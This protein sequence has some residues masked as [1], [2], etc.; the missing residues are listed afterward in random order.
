MIAKIEKQIFGLPTR[1]KQNHMK[2]NHVIINAWSAPDGQHA[3][4][5][6]I[7]WW[8]HCCTNMSVYVHNGLLIL[9]H[10]CYVHKLLL[11]LTD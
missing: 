5:H 3:C 9:L 6:K 10:M 11:S 1:N 7:T 2:C 4:L 8:H